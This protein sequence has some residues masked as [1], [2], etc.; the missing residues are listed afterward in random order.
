LSEAGAHVVSAYVNGVRFDALDRGE[1]AEEIAKRAPDGKPRIVRFCATHP[2]VLARSDSEYRELLNRGYLTV[3]DGIGPA[4]GVK[5]GGGPFRRTPGVETMQHTI[6]STALRHYFFGGTPEVLEAISRRVAEE[7]REAVVGGVEAPPFRELTD[8]EWAAA[9]GRMR[10]SGADVVWVG[11]GVPKQDFAA[12]RLQA[13]DAAPVICCV[14]AAFDFY[15]GNKRRAPRAVQ[16]LGLEW[17]FRFFQEPLRL[18]DRYLLGNALFV[19]D[20]LVGRI[21]TKAPSG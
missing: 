16:L 7:G 5:L 13:L 8:E 10:E 1:I 19:Y 12:D 4:L 17:L 6:R 20:L 21:S 18:W 15:A 14:G 3:P 11:L 9:A 2:V